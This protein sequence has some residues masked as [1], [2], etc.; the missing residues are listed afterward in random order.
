MQS[1]SSGYIY[2]AS[3]KTLPAINALGGLM[4]LLYTSTTG[5]PSQRSTSYN[6]SLLF[7][8]L[9]ALLKS[10][11][12]GKIDINC[13]GVTPMSVLSKMNRLMPESGS[14]FRMRTEV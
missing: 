14:R 1:I 4:M 9:F 5:N 2:L 12:F 3:T 13:S 11:T 6:M 8:F 7:M 10:F